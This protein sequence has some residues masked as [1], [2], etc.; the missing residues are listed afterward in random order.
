[1]IEL[2]I[3][4]AIGAFLILGAIT[5]Y[6]KARA[7]YRMTTTLARLEENA[8]FAF[9]AI[10]PDIRMAGFL[11]LTADA[12]LIAGR[13]GP[14]DPPGV[15]P[16]ASDCAPNWSIDLDRPVAAW[17]NVWAWQCR[18]RGRWASGSDSIVVRRVALEAE[19]PPLD[20]GRIYVGSSRIA[21]GSLFTG[22]TVPAGYTSPIT[23]IHRLVVNGYYISE[24]SVLDEPGHPVPS[25]RRKRLVGLRVLDEEVMPGVE[26]M[27]IELGID[28]D[29][30]GTAGRRNVDRFVH[31]DDPILD[32]ASPG[33]RPG[34]TVLAV[35][36]WLRLRAEVAERRYVDGRIYRY[37]DRQFAP[38]GSELGWRRIVVSKTIFVRNAAH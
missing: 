37:A 9:A 13:A 32:P 27:Q 36:I 33:Y 2:M 21:A 26:D 25:L 20:P 34:V 8:R 15:M 19:N 11:G 24:N 29:A 14:A 4:L 38:S 23:A 31:A 18:P 16:A 17:N 28:T 10:E 22:A 1:M 35:R 3:A 5:L 30:P 7:T 6:S 12:N